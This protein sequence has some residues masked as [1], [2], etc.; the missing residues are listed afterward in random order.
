M[1]F[2]SRFQSES[3]D[4]LE[5][6]SYDDA[7]ALPDMPDG[8]LLFLDLYMG[9]EEKGV[10]A[11]RALRERG[12]R[13]VV[14]FTTSSKDHYPEGFE[15]GAAHY[16]V[17]PFDYEVFLKAME[18]AI[19]TLG[20]TE[21][22]YGLPVARGKVSLPE[23]RIFY[24]EVYGHETFVC[25]DDDK[26]K[27]LLSLKELETILSGGPFLRCF[28]SHILNMD[29]IARMEDSHFLLTSGERVPLSLRNRQALRD[30]YMDYRFGSVREDG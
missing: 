12:W 23:S 24:A 21:R 15:V 3:G 29:K 17:K 1:G 4:V 8:A 18:R 30:K 19:K 5:I 6:Q 22:V 20:R 28:R 7:A 16:L 10:K 9:G 27:V 11:A 2:C 14:V 26:I 13:G 25:L